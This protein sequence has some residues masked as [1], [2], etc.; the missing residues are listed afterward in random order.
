MKE[1]FRFANLERTIVQDANFS[2]T[3]FSFLLVLVIFLNSSFVSSLVIGTIASIAYLVINTIFLGHALFENEDSFL[4]F[5]LGGL[6]LILVLGLSSWFMMITYNLDIFRSAIVFTV[7]TIICSLMN[8]RLTNRAKRSSQSPSS[9]ANRTRAQEG[10]PKRLPSV[11]QA[12]YLFMVT[13]SFYLLLSARSG[14]VYTVW[15]ALPVLEIPM[16]L[17]ADFV[18]IIP[19]FLLVFFAST[20]LLLTIIFSSEKTHYKLGFTI[21]HSVLSHTLFVLLFPA[22]DVGVQQVILGTTRRIYDNLTLYGYGH[23]SNI[24]IQIYYWVSGVNFQSACSVLSARMFSV[25]VFWSHLLLVPVLWGVFAPIIAFATAKTLG[26]NNTVSALSSLAISAFPATIYWGAFSVPNSLGFFFAFASLYFIL[27]YV[28]TDHKGSR[29]LML[30]F[31][32]ASFIAHFLTG[33]VVLALL[34]LAVTF[35]RYKDEKSRS[36]ITAKY[37]LI[38]SFTLS[39]SLLP[40]TLV[41]YRLLSSLYAQFSLNK[42]STLS[43]SELIGTFI[44]GEYIYYSPLNMLV[45]IL[46]PILGLIGMAYILHRNI[47]QKNRKDNMSLLFLLLGFLMI[48]I[49]YRILKLL[50]VGVPFNEERVWVFRDFILAPFLAILGYSAFLFLQRRKPL[51]ISAESHSFPLI[52]HSSFKIN[53]KSIAVYMFILLSISGWVTASIYYAYPHYAPLQTTSYELEAVRHIET[54]TQ[55]KYVVIADQ[56]IILAAQMFVGVYNSRAYYFAHTDPR[57]VALLIEMKTNPTPETMVKAMEYNNSTIAFFIIEK[58]RLGAEEY[59]RII[60]QAQQN[61]LQ[62]YP[63]G[64]FHYKDEEKLRIFY[65]QS[66][67]STA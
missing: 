29:L 35:R 64:I 24:L 30:M 42:L 33:V 59:N 11:A 37:S 47:K 15:Q 67:S 8:R 56:W 49:V 61:G 50:M 52:S 60:Q 48:F 5:M 57:G 51:N 27:R 9:Q 12:L 62:T 16:K 25:D 39:V 66:Q 14:E 36:P 28:S 65:Y 26:A 23:S 58:P 45:H 1:K 63:E 4:R 21:L 7:V 3:M 18:L 44:V 38:I 19:L 53:L 34:L 17:V 10:A 13:L 46:G 22:G 54:T 31:S 41:Y 32:F 40:L 55:E 20:F 43:T 6:F 2:F